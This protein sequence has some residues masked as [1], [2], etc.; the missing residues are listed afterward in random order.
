MRLNANAIISDIVQFS[1]LGWRLHQ[2]II[3]IKQCN[4]LG[5]LRAAVSVLRIGHHIN[6]LETIVDNKVAPKLRFPHYRVIYVHAGCIFR[7]MDM[8]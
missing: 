5:H 1:L 3:C 6:D 4:V 8:G 2:T 7:E